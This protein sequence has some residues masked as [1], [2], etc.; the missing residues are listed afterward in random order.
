MKSSLALVAAAC[1]IS[2]AV[3]STNGEEMN[4]RQ[5]HGHEEGYEAEPMNDSAAAPEEDM[6]NDGPGVIEG[7][8]ANET[9]GRRWVRS[10]YRGAWHGKRFY[11]NHFRYGY[12]FNK[13]YPYHQNCYNN[14]CG[15]V[16]YFHR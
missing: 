6:M 8:M 1:A 14:C 4:L 9:L 16:N 13:F 12:G 10:G 15:C 5:L 11:G 2:A 7:D 3:V